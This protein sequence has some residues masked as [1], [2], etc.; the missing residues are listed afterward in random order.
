VPAAGKT[1][2][3]ERVKF[4]PR[5][6]IRNRKFPESLIEGEG[7]VAGLLHGLLPGGVRGDTAEVPA[8]GAVLDEHQDVQPLQEHGINVQKVGREDPGGLGLQELPPGRARAAV[9]RLVPHP[10]G[11]TAQHCILVPEHQQLSI[12]GQVF[13]EHQDGEAQ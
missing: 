12:L 10:A 13:A 3:K 4:D 1:A 6:R 5:S 8:A 11:V 7:E 2:S 9:G